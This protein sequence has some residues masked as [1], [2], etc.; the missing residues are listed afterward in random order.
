MSELTDKE[1]HVAM[2]EKTIEITFF[3]MKQKVINSKI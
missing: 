2:Q 1:Q 3:P